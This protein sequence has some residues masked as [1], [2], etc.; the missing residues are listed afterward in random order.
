MHLQAL[1][2]PEIPITK[3]PLKELISGVFWKGAAASRYQEEASSQ[4]QPF[5]SISKRQIKAGT[6]IDREPASLA[7]NVAESLS[8]MFIHSGWLWCSRRER[9][10]TFCCLGEWEIKSKGLVFYEA[11]TG[12]AWWSLVIVALYTW[13]KTHKAHIRT[14]IHKSTTDLVRL[15]W[16]MASQK[17]L[18]H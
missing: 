10:R 15:A 7:E 14:L 4:R 3:G 16:V 13:V 9:E 2:L 1:F 18:D 11:A 6:S 12:V 5:A 17:R 8:D